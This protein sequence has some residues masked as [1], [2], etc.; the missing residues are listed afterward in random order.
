MSLTNK[1]I[2][3]AKWSFIGNV[4][5]QIT[6][7]AI[8]ILLARLLSPEEFGLIGMT[9]VFI[10]L[11]DTFVDSG[12]SQALI[13]K[14]NCTQEDYSTAFYFN[15]IASIAIYLLLFFSAGLVANFF[16]E[17]KLT[18]II[19]VA[20]LGMVINS[21][22]LVQKTIL[23]K[24]ISFK[25]QTKISVIST[26]LSGTIAIFMAINDFGVWSL[27]A[28]SL[29]ASLISATLFWG[30]NKWRP[31]FVFSKKSFDDLFSFGSKL[32]LSNLI[33]RFYWNLYYVVIGKYFSSETLGYYTRAEMFKNLPSQNIT[34][35]IN[36][37]SYPSLSIIQDNDIELK[38]SFKKIMLITFFITT[39]LL[40][41]IFSVSQSLIVVILGEKWLGS[42]EYL[43]LLC[44]SAI[45]FSPSLLNTTIMKIKNR[46][47]LLLKL[48]P[49]KKIIMIPSLFIG[50]IF[51]INAMIW[52]LI[53]YSILDWFLNVRYGGKLINYSVKS[54]I[55]DMAPIIMICF[56]IAC[57]LFLID[58]YIDFSAFYKLIIQTIIAVLIF[59][60]L[61]EIVKLDY[62][63]FL[64]SF[65]KN[66]IFKLKTNGF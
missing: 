53:I 8:G 6:T 35:I 23:V 15:L 20:S 27:V 58:I 14:N 46:S 34:S 40:T 29:S 3:G 10:V 5:N 4:S 16:S 55:F 30:S 7:F 47:D 51:G 37:V 60:V 17:P 36:N 48:E 33:D 9:T 56:V 13:R 64:K 38:K 39:L 45:L 2:N 61:C 52:F 21:L 66:L 31:D 18:N 57:P 49:I 65:F 50:V 59:I 24:E 41:Y 11:A 28:K 12:F 22:V 43:R 44:L 19:R 1:T 42:V 62:Y 32:L 25:I 63:F 26:I 54:Q